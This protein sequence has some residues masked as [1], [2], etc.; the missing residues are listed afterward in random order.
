MEL[1]KLKII[2]QNFENYFIFQLLFRCDTVLNVW[3]PS[4]PAH[5]ACTERSLS[6]Q[7]SSGMAE[8]SI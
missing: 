8:T 5:S 2:V 7:S 3:K 6:Y 4:Q 1:G